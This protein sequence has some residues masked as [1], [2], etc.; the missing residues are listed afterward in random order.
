VPFDLQTPF[1]VGQAQIPLSHPAIGLMLMA[2]GQFQAPRGS[3][4]SDTILRAATRHP[5]PRGRATSRGD[6]V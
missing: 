3:S 6:R 4:S 1:S 5:A 2:R